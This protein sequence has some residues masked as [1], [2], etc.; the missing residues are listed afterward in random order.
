MI[1]EE[2]WENAARAANNLSE[3]TRTLGEVPRA[4]ALRA[5]HVSVLFERRPRAHHILRDA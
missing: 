4:V 3:L 1:T 5:I 2:G